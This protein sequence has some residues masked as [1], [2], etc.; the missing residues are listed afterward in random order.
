[1]AAESSPLGNSLEICPSLKQLE[2]FYRKQV[3]VF[4]G[5]FIRKLKDG[6][7]YRVTSESP[8][9]KV[10]SLEVSKLV[11]VKSLAS[12]FEDNEILQRSPF[13]CELRTLRRICNIFGED[14]L[15]RRFN[16]GD[17]TIVIPFYAVIQDFTYE[18]PE[19][20]PLEICKGQLA[21]AIE[22]EGD[23]MKCLIPY[24]GS[25][26]D[27]DDTLPDGFSLHTIEVNG[28]TLQYPQYKGSG[29]LKVAKGYNFVY[30]SCDVLVPED[31]LVIRNMTFH[32]IA[33]VKDLFDLTDTK[34]LVRLDR[35]PS[36][37]ARRC[38]FHI[39]R[40][41]KIISRAVFLPLTKLKY[42]RRV[43]LRYH[44]E[45]VNLQQG[46]VQISFFNAAFNKLES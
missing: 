3:R 16:S 11:F 22:H 44:K 45:D 27:E 35:S 30:S 33:V 6:N 34:D 5:K 43:S 19:V 7:L 18:L 2:D 12:R 17:F 14:N 40:P 20:N 1:M 38:A 31:T 25:N 36:F 39:K 23:N 13:I 32:V 28:N 21:L 26:P 29:T 24:G 10:I 46:E 9:E 37:N 15:V 41:V 4:E 42:V 8:R